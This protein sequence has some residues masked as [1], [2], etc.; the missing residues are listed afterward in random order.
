MQVCV[1]ILTKE[2]CRKTEKHIAVFID[3]NPFI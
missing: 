2:E 3:P 1:Q